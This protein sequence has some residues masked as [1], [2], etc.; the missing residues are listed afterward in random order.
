MPDPFIDADITQPTGTSSAYLA[1]VRLKS[2]NKNI[3]RALMSLA[4]AA[5]LIRVMGLV[6]Q[7]IVTGRFGLGDAMDA[8]FV[9]ALVPSLV[10]QLIG[11]TVEYSV[12]P[13]YI[14][15]RSQEGRKRASEL[16]STLLN[17]L[18]V[19]TV[20]LMVVMFIFRYQV[21][22][23]SAPALGSSSTGLAASLAPFIIPI[24]VLQVLISLLESILNAEGQYGWPAYAGMLVPLTTAIFV[25]V[26][27][28]YFGIVALCVGGLVGL[29]LQL[30]VFFI[31]VRQAKLVYRLNINLR[32]PAVA[33]IARLVRS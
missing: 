12:V 22:H 18:L 3:F 20:V 30:F 27:G 21:V 6:Y 11:G 7:I 19:G 17:V 10:A 13:V 26:V 2:P 28:K 29:C 24:L 25:L 1:A 16:F 32:N 23:L 31:R 5:L 33:S 4:S 8:Y 9:A 14:R 15:V